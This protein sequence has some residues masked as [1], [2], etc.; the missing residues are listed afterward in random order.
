VEEKDFKNQFI[1]CF[2]A[3]WCANKYEDCCARGEQSVLGN[4]PVED[5]EDMA[6]LAWEEILKNLKV[7]SYKQR[8][9]KEWVNLYHAV[10]K[11]MMTLGVDGKIK[12]VASYVM[13]SLAAIDGG[14][15]DP[16]L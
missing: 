10:Y 7:E 9:P 6:G 4:P 12:D 8:P 14:Q 1:A 13:E 3:S 16:D 2:L 5:A 11:M 15:Y